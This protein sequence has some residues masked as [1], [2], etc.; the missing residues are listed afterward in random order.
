MTINTTDMITMIAAKAKV[1]PMI[2]AI[3]PFSMAL[4]FSLA[5]SACVVASAVFFPCDVGVGVVVL[6]RISPGLRPIK[7]RRKKPLN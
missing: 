1:T 5:N 3:L 4:T 7:W 6:N 2:S